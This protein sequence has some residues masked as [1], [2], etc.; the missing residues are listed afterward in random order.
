[1]QI[2]R[3]DSKIYELYLFIEGDRVSKWP[4]KYIIGLTGNIAT[5]KSV[6]R[7]MLEH[8]GAYTIDADALAH[9]AIAKDAPGYKPVLE[10]FGKWILDADGQINRSKLGGLV[11]RDSEALG[12]LEN[13]VHPLVGQAIE[14]LVQRASQ[15]VVVIEAIKLIES[16]LRTACDSIW[17][18]YAPEEVQIERLMRKRSFTRDAAVER[19][20]SQGAQSEKIERAN[21]VIRNTSSYDELWKQVTTAWKQVSPT[22]DTIPVLMKKAEAGDFSVQRGRPR[23]SDAIADIIN[24]LSHSKQKMSKLDVMEAFGEKAFLLL[25]LDGHIVGL[26]GWQVENLVARTT[27]LFIE[28]EHMSD[29]ALETLVMEVERASKDLQCE[30]S[31][32][33]PLPDLASYETSWKKLGYEP[34]TPEK[35]GVQAWQDAALESTL[36]GTELMFKQ[37]RV[38]RVLR[39]I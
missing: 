27:D 21:T 29:K 2:L 35:L 6:V 24:R 16:E 1:M 17:V 13:I 10:T 18:T 20:H 11:F 7:R 19:I 23:D 15:R 31:L 36:P 8:L 12:K 30:A 14:I 28:P 9:R 4:G 22:S 3:K 34:R 26:A 37:L 32:I 38:D 39:P 33:F 25:Q 5:G